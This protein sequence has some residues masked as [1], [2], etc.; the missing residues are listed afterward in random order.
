MSDSALFED[1]PLPKQWPKHVRSAIVHVISLAHWAIVYTR[2]V[3]ADSPLTRVRLKAQL[4]QAT[5][6]I[7]LLTEELRIKEA[8]MA[9]LDARHRPHYL[10]TD[11]LAILEMKAAR[12]CI[13]APIEKEGNGP[14]IQSL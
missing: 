9:R 1:V 12:G 8:R 14:P 4:E 10:P 13:V 5:N 3:A 11:R 6:E 7:C 2:S